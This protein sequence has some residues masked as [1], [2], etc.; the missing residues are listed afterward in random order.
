MKFSTKFVTRTGLLIALTIG[1]QLLSRTVGGTT[2]ITGSLVNMMLIISAAVLGWQGGAIVGLFT[3]LIAVLIGIMK[4]PILVPAI[5]IANGVLVVS[6]ALLKEH[7]RYLGVGV[8]AVLK[9]LVLAV[10]VR[11]LI[12]VPQPVV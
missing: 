9:F 4:F 8:G 10:A 5:I 1:L 6:Y 3:P 7:N 11:Y 2:L 12:Q